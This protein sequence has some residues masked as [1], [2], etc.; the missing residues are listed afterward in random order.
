M[1]VEARFLRVL[2]EH[3][4]K[5]L[6]H[7]RDALYFSLPANDPDYSKDAQLKLIEP[8]WVKVIQAGPKAE[9]FLH[10]MVLMM[11]EEPGI[12]FE[13]M[14]RFRDSGY[15]PKDADEFVVAFLM[16]VAATL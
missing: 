11:R 2:R 6:I 15:E 7:M 9:D 5:I 3:Q 8:E 12:V 13:A 16:F 14:L 10:D 1:D 4:P